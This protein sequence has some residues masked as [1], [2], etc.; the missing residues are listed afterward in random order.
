MVACRKQDD[1]WVGTATPCKPSEAPTP[2]V[3]PRQRL[4][5][6]RPWSAQRTKAR[7]RQSCS[8]QAPI[9]ARTLARTSASS[10]AAAR[11]LRCALRAR[12]SRLLTWSASTAV[13]TR[14]CSRTSKG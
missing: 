6:Q 13:A 8:G 10:G 14:P 3:L 4:F 5:C 12:Q 1:R 2:K 9:S 7:Q 11:P